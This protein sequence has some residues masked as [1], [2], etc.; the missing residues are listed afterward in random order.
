MGSQPGSLGRRIRSNT[1]D[2][3]RTRTP[4]HVEQENPEVRIQVKAMKTKARARVAE[5][6]E[7]RA[8]WEQMREI[9]PPYDAYQAKTD[10]E[11]P[12]V[13]LEPISE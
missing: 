2:V 5:G 4:A 8:I 13:V 10:R 7:R 6:E 3:R 11:I 1:L 12:V 9:Y